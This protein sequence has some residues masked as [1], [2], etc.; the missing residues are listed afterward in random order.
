MRAKFLITL[1]I[2]IIQLVCFGIYKAH[3][4]DAYSITYNLLTKQTDV[5]FLFMLLAVFES[6]LCCIFV[7]LYVTE[8]PNC[9]I[10]AVLKSSLEM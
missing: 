8:C 6:Y 4:T 2:K 9:T 3:F 7:C 1:I 5:A 10:S